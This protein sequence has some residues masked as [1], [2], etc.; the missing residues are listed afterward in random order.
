MLRDQQETILH[1]LRAMRKQINDLVAGQ[2]ILQAKAEVPATATLALSHVQEAWRAASAA[3]LDCARLGA[4]L[5][6]AEQ[7]HAVA[8]VLA[9]QNLSPSPTT[10]SHPPIPDVDAVTQSGLFN[11]GYDNEVEMLGGND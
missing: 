2:L 4:T 11:T 3:T 8:Q 6:I 9:T 1:E 10:N 7:N 5:K